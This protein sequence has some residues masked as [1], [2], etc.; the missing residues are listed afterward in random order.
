MISETIPTS[1]DTKARA[2]PRP[3]PFQRFSIATVF[4]DAELELMKLQ[5]RSLARHLDTADLADIYVIFNSARSL[6]SGNRA[7][8]LMNYGPLASRVQFLNRRAIGRI[9]LT[10]GWKSQQLLKLLLAE[11][12]STPHYVVLD[13]KT[14]LI[15]RLD[16]SFLATND[17]RATV[18]VYSYGGHPLEGALRHVTGVLKAPL[19]TELDPFPAT[20]PPITLCTD[21][22]RDLL[23]WST[24]KGVNTFAKFFLRND[25]TEFF[26]Y[27]AWLKGAAGGLEAFYY[28]HQRFCP[29][30]WGHTTTKEAVAKALSLAVDRSLPFLSTHRR[31]L[32]KV[33]SPA[34]ELL[35]AFWVERALFD[36][37]ADAYRFIEE[38]RHAVRRTEWLTQLRERVDLCFSLPR[39]ALRKVGRLTKPPCAS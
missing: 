34:Q 39:R 27:F 5:A 17:G 38:T 1:D 33:D 29:A 12:V 23:A 14:H 19:N 15:S 37:Q 6:R 3:Q 7:A 13:A 21:I 30:L 4:F 25:L 11:K 20:V 8:L 18:N 10:S 28:P 36:T 24:P 32:A 9:P 22:V 2:T 26:Y 31:S 35:S 16:R